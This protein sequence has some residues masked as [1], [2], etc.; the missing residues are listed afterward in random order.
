MAKNLAS[1]IR[2]VQEFFDKV[3]P[4]KGGD[5]IVWI[6]STMTN[7]S[8]L[9]LNFKSDGDVVPVPPIPVGDPMQLCPTQ[10]PDVEDIVK[11][12]DVQSLATKGYIQLLTNAEAETFFAK[13]AALLGMKPE[14]VMED[15]L[16]AQ[17]N[18]KHKG[19]PVETPD[20][21]G[22]DQDG[23]QH[24]ISPSVSILCE[25]ASN[26]RH[27]NERA[28]SKDVIKRLYEL[29]EQI[30]LSEIE[31]CRGKLSHLPKV[32]QLLDDLA[33]DRA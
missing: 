8:Q 9:V 22:V 27:P 19:A 15:A 11:N 26:E 33:K 31:Y 3:R 2:S 7:G 24:V 30:S 18:T 5:G 29:R 17:L 13:K 4:S 25:E 1:S 12:R 23:F 20:R 16:Q 14:E 10:I 28:N 21:K 32:I 6:R